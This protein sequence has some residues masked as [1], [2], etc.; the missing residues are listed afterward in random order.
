[1]Y[2]KAFG[3]TVSTTNDATIA[4]TDISAYTSYWATITTAHT[5]TFPTTYVTG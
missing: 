5:T 1:M 4:A 3:A 2:Q